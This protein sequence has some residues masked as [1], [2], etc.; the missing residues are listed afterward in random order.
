MKI[1][2]I[3]PGSRF[4]GWG[5]VEL[6]HKQTAY[7]A[8]GTLRLDA[9]AELAQRL[10]ALSHGVQELLRTHRPDQAALERIFAARNARSALVLGHARGVILCDLARA[11]LPLFE[12]TATQV[13]QAV[14][15]GGRAGKD[16]VLA[17][18]AML[19]RHRAPLQEDEADALAVA[20]THAHALPFA[21]AGK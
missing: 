15:G 20:L 13:K 18:V 5:V 7:V 6:R 4:T 9:Q 2:G 17:M 3:D 11:G 19:L 16:Q 14:V 10:V 21:E 1:L 12:Y 8:S